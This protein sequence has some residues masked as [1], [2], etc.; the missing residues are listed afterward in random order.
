MATELKVQSRSVFGKK[1]AALRHAGFVPG[2]IYGHGRNNLHVAVPLKEFVALYRAAG[3]H[4]VISVATEEGAI[5]AVI[6]EVAYHPLSDEILAIDF[7]AVKKGE[8]VRAKA[9]VA[10]VGVAPA[11]KA[12]FVVVEVVHEIEIEALPEHLLHKIEVSLEKLE[13][14]GDSVGIKDLSLPSTVKLHV[15]TDTT[16]ATVRE[17]AR[18]ATISPPVAETA[19]PAEEAAT[20]ENAPAQPE[21]K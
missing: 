13:K 8:R 16:L 19:T 17:H 9:P 15:P 6:A 18:E 5:P 20:S 3:S 14:P 10:F 11:T 7:H 1:T 21:K 4:T 2:E 12:G